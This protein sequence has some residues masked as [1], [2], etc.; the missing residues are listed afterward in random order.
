MLIRKGRKCV[1]MEEYQIPSVRDAALNIHRD[2]IIYTESIS[3]RIEV[4]INI[5]ILISKGEI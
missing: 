3:I 1:D 5:W 2:R 4:Y